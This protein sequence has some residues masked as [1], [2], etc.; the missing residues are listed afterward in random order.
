MLI[1]TRRI[2]ESIII[3]EDIHITVLAVD[4]EFVRLGINE[5]SLILERLEE[6]HQKKEQEKKTKDHT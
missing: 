2:N 4:G 1:L 5:P 3:G 6:N